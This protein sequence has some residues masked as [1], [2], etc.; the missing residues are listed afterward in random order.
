MT[1]T[2]AKMAAVLCGL[3]MAGAG[4]I[5]GGMH[6]LD[7]SQVS[8]AS[9]NTQAT[10][11]TTGTT[12]T[13]Q[14][15]STT[16]ASAQ[17]K[18]AMDKALEIA[19]GQAQGDVHELELDTEDGALT[20]KV[21]L[22]N[23]TV[24]INADDGTVLKVET[25][26]TTETYP[27]AKITIEKAIEI[28]QGKAQGDFHEAELDTKDGALVWEVEIGNSEVLIDAQDGTV[29]SVKESNSNHDDEDDNDSNE[30]DSDHEDGNGDQSDD[31]ENDSASSTDETAALYTIVNR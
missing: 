13:G 3:S 20:W 7:A 6:V 25:E 9:I 27:A 1:L 23:A 18:I 4:M 17:P 28:A 31:N 21:G 30:H 11:S 2:K 26:D 14:D 24:Y 12:A 16:Q 29:I 5:S 15:Q 10:P 19:R 8:A 22:G